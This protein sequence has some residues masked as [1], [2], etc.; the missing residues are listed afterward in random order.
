MNTDSGL[1]GSRG[2]HQQPHSHV[3]ISGVATQ[4]KTWTSG[5]CERR[6]Y[7]GTLPR[8]SGRLALSGSSAQP[9]QRSPRLAPVAG[10]GPFIAC[11]S[12]RSKHEAVPTSR[13]SRRSGRLSSPSGPTVL[14]PPRRPAGCSTRQGTREPFC[15]CG[16]HS[17]GRITPAIL[18]VALPPVAR[19]RA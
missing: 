11:A 2:F 18:N 9:A 12:I 1:D 4:R 13:S 14:S 17:R 19:G 6:G 10:R 16:P 8:S 3:P 7:W 15:P 5:C